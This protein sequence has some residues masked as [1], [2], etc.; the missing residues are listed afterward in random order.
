VA[1]QGDE[2]IPDLIVNR[3]VEEWWPLLRAAAISASYPAWLIA[4]Y[5]EALADGTSTCGVRWA[6]S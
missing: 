3:K 2:M 4:H 1:L 5:P 6:N